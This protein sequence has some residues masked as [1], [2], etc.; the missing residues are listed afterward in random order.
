MSDAFKPPT[1]VV[2]RSV[3]LTVGFTYAS[4]LLALS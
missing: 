2:V 3:D 4:A 1:S